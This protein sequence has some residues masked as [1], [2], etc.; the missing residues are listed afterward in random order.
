M[1]VEHL[2]V[3]SDNKLRSCAFLEGWEIVC[4]CMSA[5]MVFV[6]L[7]I[8]LVACVFVC[9]H[10][11]V[12]SVSTSPFSLLVIQFN[13]SWITRPGLPQCRRAK[14]QDCSVKENF[15]PD[16]IHRT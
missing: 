12:W 6:Q 10:V 2:S 15:L 14:R 16:T 4:V 3:S 7:C 11:C 8:L 9:A 1:F 13:P 5:I